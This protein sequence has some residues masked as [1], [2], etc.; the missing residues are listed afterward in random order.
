MLEENEVAL[1]DLGGSEIYLTLAGSEE[2]VSPK[3]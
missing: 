3:V 2:I 1:G